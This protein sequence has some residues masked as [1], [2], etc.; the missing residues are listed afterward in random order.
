MRLLDLTLRTLVEDEGVRG[1]LARRVGTEAS[2]LCI[3]AIGEH[4]APLARLGNTPDAAV[5]DDLVR[6]GDAFAVRSREVMG[7]LKARKPADPAQPG[8]TAD[9]ATLLLALVVPNVLGLHDEAVAT[10][11]RL[12]AAATAR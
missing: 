2:R 5:R 10:A 12:R 9:L 11:D 3:T 4:L 6:L 7:R 1:G 8:D